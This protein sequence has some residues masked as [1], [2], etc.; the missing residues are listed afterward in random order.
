ML[1]LVGN[2]E[3]LFSRDAAQFLVSYLMFLNGALHQVKPYCDHF[4]TVTFYRNQEN[5]EDT[6][7]LKP[8]KKSKCNNVHGLHKTDSDR[9]MRNQT[10][11]AVKS[12]ERLTT[13][14]L[15]SLEHAVKTHFNNEK[16]TF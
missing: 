1:D 6:F 2:P 10:K 3:D 12:P 7:R 8:N 15:F 9:I 14:S 16:K 4:R 5:Y 11:K 13:F